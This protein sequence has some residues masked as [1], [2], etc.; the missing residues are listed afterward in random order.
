M[1]VFS[2]GFIFIFIATL[3]QAETP[4]RIV[5]LGGALTEIVYA[6]DLQTRL[7]GVD[8]SSIYPQAATLLPQVGYYRAFSIEGVV[9]LRPD[10]VLA[11]DQAG[12]P[13]A[14]QKLQQLAL[15]V[16]VLPGDH[17]V[18]ALEQRIRGVA[19]HVEQRE[20]GELLIAQIHRSLM[21]P[22][23][24]AGPRTLLL[25]GR[26]GRLQGAGADTAADAMLHLAGAVNVL[27]AQQGYKPLSPEAAAALSPD[28]IVATRMTVESLGGI[29][30][31]LDMPGIKLTPA[32]RQRRVIVMDDLLL[33][34]F[35]P[36]LPEAL[37]ELR[38]GLAA[39]AKSR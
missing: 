30:K 10:L 23:N 33:L 3:T 11:S 27:A 6:L 38:T 13:A 25:M 29:D 36:R 28:V 16:V 20:R 22:T 26:D 18:E 9:A 34:G 35:G 19:A 21:P 1:R 7:V 32:V 37:R 24:Q 2:F 15:R 12:P 39:S 4:Q 8:Q 5:T 31:L 14:L 17:T